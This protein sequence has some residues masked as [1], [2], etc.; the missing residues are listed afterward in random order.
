MLVID[1]S[2]FVIHA[3]FYAF[4]KEKNGESG[5]NLVTRRLSDVVYITVS[6]E[7]DVKPSLSLGAKEVA[8]ITKGSV[9]VGGT[10]AFIHQ[11]N[12]TDLFRMFAYKSTNPLNFPLFTI[13]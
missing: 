7:E 3:Y 6:A 2:N 8:S 4:S 10:M 9:F 13:V 1:G 11:A 5:A 12:E